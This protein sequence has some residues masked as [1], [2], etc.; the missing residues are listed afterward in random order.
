MKM[1]FALLM[2]MCSVMF[3][4]CGH[5]AASKPVTKIDVAKIVVQS[6]IDGDVKAMETVISAP[7]FAEYAV[8]SYGPDFAGYKLDDFTFT[9][10][11]DLLGEDVV[12]VKSKNGKINQTLKIEKLGDRYV[13]NG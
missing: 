7:S 13:Y 12:I 11:K 10:T 2:L 3:A 4:G 6:L 8:S 9:D 1:K 5:H